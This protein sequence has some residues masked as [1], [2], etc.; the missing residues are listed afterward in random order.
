MAKA[1]ALA[2]A[3][4]MRGFPEDPLG[5]AFCID[6]RGRVQSTTLLDVQA[7]EQ[8]RRLRVFIAAF[9]REQDRWPASLEE[10]ADMGYVRSPPRHPNER[11]RFY[12]DPNTGEL[13]D[14]PI[15]P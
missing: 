5:G 12:Y 8:I 6:S 15:A 1:K 13:A 7:S 4:Y 9:R 3:G 11:K 14:S 2:D 10:L